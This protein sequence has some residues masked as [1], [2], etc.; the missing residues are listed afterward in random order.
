MPRAKTTEV[1]GLELTSLI[2]DLGE[3]EIAR[4]QNGLA[5]PKGSVA[6]INVAILRCQ[7][8]G[9]RLA[10]AR[11]FGLTERDVLLATIDYLREHLAA[12]TKELRTLTS[13]TSNQTEE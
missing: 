8:N 13:D 9:L 12:K 3:V 6:A 4:Q 11:Q 2:S 5:S 7:V 1:L 10:L